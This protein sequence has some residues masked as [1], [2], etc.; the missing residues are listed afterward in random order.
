METEQQEQNGSEVAEKSSGFGEQLRLAREAAGISTADAATS[1]HLD[2]SVIEALEAE[3]VDAIGAPVF[4]KGHLRG[5]A[6]LLGLSVEDLTAAYRQLD[7]HSDEWHAVNARTEAIRWANM[8]QW[9]L[10]FLVLIAVVL[11]AWYLFKGESPQSRP[12]SPATNVP[13]PGV[14]QL[15]LSQD[16]SDSIEFAPEN[17]VLPAEEN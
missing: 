6:R 4:V 10:V 3:D 16:T 5:Y 7:P 2:A 11:V 1:L 14:L 8:P 12:A 9:G 13:A 17:L 15:P